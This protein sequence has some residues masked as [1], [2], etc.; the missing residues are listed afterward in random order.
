MNITE[1]KKNFF[2]VVILILTLITVIV[3][4]AFAIYTFLHSQ[5]EGSSNVYTGTL[6]L[7][8][9]SG[10]RIFLKSIYPSHDPKI[11]TEDNVYKNIFT[12]KNTGT[13]DG[14]LRV[15]VDIRKNEFTNNALKYKLFSNDGNEIIKGDIPKEG[16]FEV[17]SNI[18]LPGNTESEF[19]LI[20]W[21]EET[22]ENQNTEM[23]KTLLGAIKAEVNQKID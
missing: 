9:K 12:I 4:A 20:I 7:E 10:T 8:Y 19:T 14:I 13:L 21:L 16:N 6:A 1:D 17:A 11:D 15:I 2:Y 5:E 3:G 23:R 22:G 18:L